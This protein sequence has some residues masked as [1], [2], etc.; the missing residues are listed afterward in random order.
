MYQCIQ[1]K[2]SFVKTR[3]GECL[4]SA[5]NLANCDMAST[6]TLCDVCSSGFVLVGITAGRV[7]QAGAVTDCVSYWNNRPQS[8]DFVMLDDTVQFCSQCKP[9]Y[10][11]NQNECSKGN[12][13]NCEIMEDSDRCSSCFAGFTLVQM[14]G[15]VHYCYKNDPELGCARF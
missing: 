15:G 12:V 1:C 13:A 2:A 9:N 11:L 5:G 6:T 4:P 14:K 8:S 7:C 10:Y 3:M